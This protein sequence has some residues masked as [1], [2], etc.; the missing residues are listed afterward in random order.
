M[1]TNLAVALPNRCFECLPPGARYRDLAGGWAQC[2][3]FLSSALPLRAE[4][5]LMQ[6]LHVDE[7]AAKT[8]LP[9][10]KLG[11]LKLTHS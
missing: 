4:L 1:F 7:I 10:Q 2:K 8:K 11:K 5:G 6:G 3:S 9:S